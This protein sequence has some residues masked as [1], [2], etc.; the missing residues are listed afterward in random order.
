M[1]VWTCSQLIE[2]F[3]NRRID[4]EFFNPTYIKAETGTLQCHT[5]NLG[6]LGYF[7]PGPFGSAF[8]VQNYNFKSAYRYIRGRDVKPFFLLNDDNRYIHESDFKRMI[9]YSVF[10]Q[11]LMISVVGTLGN[12]AICTDDDTPAIFSCKSTIF[13]GNEIDPYYLLAYLNSYYGRM[14]LLRRQRGA[15]Q[16]GLNIEDLRGIPVPRFNDGIEKELALLVQS[17]HSSSRYA[18]KCYCQAQHLLE[19]E[20]GLDKLKF[21]KPVGYTA[22]FSTVGLSDAFDAGRID[23]QCFAPNAVFYENWFRNHAQFDR[24]NHL[25]KAKLKG[26]QQK[27]TEKGSLD[28]CS[29]KHISDHELT[30]A[31]KCR[32]SSDTPLADQ[33]DLLLAITGATI[34]KIGIVRRYKQLAFSGDL[35]CLKVSSKIDPHYL[36][37]VLGYAIGQVQLVRWITGSTNGHLAP[38]DVGRVLIPRLNN[39]IESRIAGLVEESLNK[40]L[41]SEKK[42][43]QAKARVEQLIEEAASEG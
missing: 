4:S 9:K 28:Y 27:E 29:I 2:T 5:E 18:K 16:T 19:S 36:L 38:R 12:V 35:L 22:R 20:L 15:V 43:D 11:D 34:G 42:L 7:V 23:A 14:C 40:R 1:A 3:S 39:D 13:R 25:L 32:P 8:H 26:R 31:S 24:L 41:E 21:K 33:N 30:G 6:R 37:V 10:P 17:S